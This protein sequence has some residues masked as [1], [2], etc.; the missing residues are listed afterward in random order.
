KRRFVPWRAAKLGKGE[1]DGPDIVLSCVA[2]KAENRT[3]IDT[4]REKHSD[5]DVSKQMG[6][7]AIERRRPHAIVQVTDTY[8]VVR[9]VCKKRGQVRE[10]FGLARTR[11]VPPLRVSRRQG[12]DVAIERERF[13]YAAK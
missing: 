8:W 10:R 7:H 9:P 1:G 12:A 3:G 6:A 5:L 2:H 11:G 4:P 13:G